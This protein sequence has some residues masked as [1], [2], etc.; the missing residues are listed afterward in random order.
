MPAPDTVD[1]EREFEQLVRDLRALPTAAPD[2]IRTR[3][4]SLGE[5]A[6]RRW[7]FPRIG[8][9]RAM[10]VL[11]PACLLALVSAAVVHGLLSSSSRKN[12]DT[13]AAARAT[14][15]SQHAG[16][17]RGP[18]LG[19]LKSAPSYGAGLSPSAAPEIPAPNP[20]RHQDYQADLR[21]RVKDLDSLGRQTAQAMRV[22]RDLGGYVASVEQST[23]VGQPGEADLSLRIPV[24]HVQDALIQLSALGTVLEQH[25]SIVDLENSVQQQRQRIR[26]L[27]LQIVRIEGALQQSLP[28]DVRLRLQ[29]Q[30]DDARRNLANATGANKATLREAALSTVSLSLTTQHVV[31]VTKHHRGLLGRAT[32][33]AVDFLAAAGAIALA[34]LIVLSPL[35]VLALVAWYAVRSWRRRE[36]RR[37]LAGT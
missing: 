9:R 22:T 36:E 19:P 31:A 4:R 8:V 32:S 3:V 20:T 7:V 18:T 23:S 6:P 5:P 24:A 30:L 35:L 2:E 16:A 17:A 34:A 27:Q 33:G 29:F 15:G 12:T 13:F 1:F 21:V 10:L 11:V 14:P 28:A 26:A 37:L 25:V